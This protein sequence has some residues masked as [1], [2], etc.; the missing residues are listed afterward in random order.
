M[1]IRFL[2]KR[3]FVWER[4]WGGVVVGEGSIKDFSRRSGFR[5]KVRGRLVFVEFER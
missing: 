4:E 5:G 3:R 2:R 1:R